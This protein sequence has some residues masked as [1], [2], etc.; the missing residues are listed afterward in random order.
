MKMILLISCLLSFSAMAK[1][2]ECNV[3][4]SI[5]GEDLVFKVKKEL[6]KETTEQ[7]YLSASK[8]INPA[9]GRF[10]I[11]V[12]A[13]TTKPGRYLLGAKVIDKQSGGVS[14]SYADTALLNL[15]VSDADAPNIS[16]LVSIKCDVK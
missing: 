15:F 6:K 9:N 11:D 2:L 5:D 13:Q 12:F 4:Y 10:T 16:T 14:T 7:I 8:T 3:I 1:N